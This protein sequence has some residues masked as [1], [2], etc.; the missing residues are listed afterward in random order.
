MRIDKTLSIFLLCFFL[1]QF[2]SA[3]DKIRKHELGIDIA[4]VLTFLKRNNQSYLINY[5]YR[6]N[7]NIRIRAGVNLDIGTGNSEG[8]YPDVRFGFQKDKKEG[9]W[10]LYMGSD[11]SYSFFKSNALSGNVSRYGLS[12]L[13]GVQY[14][15]NNK[16]SISTEATL[17]GYLY[18]NRQK[19]TFVGDANSTSFRVSIGSI[20]MM[21]INYHF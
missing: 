21:V 13:V 18:H 19:N 7:E 5:R 4:N 1:M 14:F 8:I 20:G 11:V 2:V 17:N 6:I 16:I 15:F 10:I 9:H 12:P 3:Q